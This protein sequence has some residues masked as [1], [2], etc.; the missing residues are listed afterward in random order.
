MEVTLPPARGAT[1]PFYVPHQ[2]GLPDPQAEARMLMAPS[3]RDP[4]AGMKPLCTTRDILAI[5]G[6]RR[7]RPRGARHCL[8]CRRT[9]RRDARK[10]AHP[11]GRLA[12]RGAGAARHEQGPA[13]WCMGRM[14]CIPATS[15]P[16]R[17]RSWRTASCSPT[18][19][20]EPVRSRA[21]RSCWNA[22]CA[23]CPP[24]AAP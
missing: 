23:T 7:A 22:F 5:N 21:S 9:A 8:L 10:P 12:A 17:L 3:G 1:R 19:R 16:W 24:R 2:L 15:A 13:R 20:W 18:P 4:L 11:A 14:R 6:H